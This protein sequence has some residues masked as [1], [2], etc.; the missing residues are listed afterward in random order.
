M[1]DLTR[2]YDTLTADERFRLFIEAASREDIQELDRLNDTCPRKKYVC[3][4]WDYTR[5]KVRFLDLALLHANEVA[6]VEC[7]AFATLTLLLANDNDPEAAETV[8][9]LN[10]ALVKLTIRRLS[11][12]EGWNR[13][14][15][16]LG[17]S[18]EGFVFPGLGCGERAL[19]MDI[20]DYAVAGAMEM[21]LEPDESQAAARLHQWHECW[22]GGQ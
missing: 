15:T 11:M 7:V 6:N 3:D 4:D 9:K 20:V 1:R 14:C 18:P 10:E 2:H 8:G 12:I 22:N 5:R 13:F 17:L 19:L 21:T 16:D